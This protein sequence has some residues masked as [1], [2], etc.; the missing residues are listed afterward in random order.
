MEEILAS[1]RR[2]ISEDGEEEGA[3]EAV[4]EAAPVP[5]P[6]PEPEPVPEPEPEPE[7]QPVPEP[8]PAPEP[9]VLELTEV[10]VE[11]PDVLELDASLEIVEVVPEPQPEP[12]PVS[13]PEPVPAAPVADVGAIVSDATAAATANVFTQ[14]AGA[15]SSAKGIPL[16]GVGR[17][18]EELVK[19]LLRPML[20]DWLDRNLEAIVNRAVE[21]EMSKLAGSVD[22]E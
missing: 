1:I 2:I 21:R 17:T 16:G 8:E 11:E 3:E 7:P 22:D 19:E 14:F 12:V 6:E 13:V 10:V 5:E 20:K 9:E 15:V 4:A 18:L